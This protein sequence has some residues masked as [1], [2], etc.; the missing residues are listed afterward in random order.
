MEDGFAVLASARLRIHLFAQIAS[1]VSI[2]VEIL[3]YTTIPHWSKLAL[4]RAPLAPREPFLPARHHF[5][6]S[7]YKALPDTF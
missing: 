2:E 7:D 1:I 3:P 4:R 6:E 5:A